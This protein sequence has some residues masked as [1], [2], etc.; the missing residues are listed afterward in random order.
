MGKYDHCWKWEGS[1]WKS[2]SAWY[3]WLRGSMRRAWNKH[4]LK[5]AFLRHVRRLIDNPNPT[6]AKRFPQVWGADCECCGGTFALSGGKREGGKAAKIQVD[7]RNAAGTF[8]KVQDIQKFYERLMCIGIEDL[9]AVCDV[10]NK[11][12]A[13][14]ESKGW[15]FERASA[16]RK[17]IEIIKLKQDK[18]WLQDHGINP[19][20]A[21]ANRRKQIVEKIMESEK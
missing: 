2:E 12:L 20:S 19:A 11:T 13:L 10:C 9:R 4:P 16:E 6:S 8:T 18:Q 7:H 14:A 15:T 17:A 3:G 5:I 1:P 21:Q